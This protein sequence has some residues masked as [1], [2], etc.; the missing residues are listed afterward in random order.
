MSSNNTDNYMYNRLYLKNVPA[1]I[2]KNQLKNIFFKDLDNLDIHFPKNQK[3]IIP[4]KKVAFIQFSTPNEGKLARQVINLM[5]WNNVQANFANKA[6]SDNKIISA[7]TNQVINEEE[8]I[9][10][11]CGTVDS[12]F[13]CIECETLYYSTFYCSAEHQQKDWPRHKI[14]CKKLP[15]LKRI[16]ERQNVFKTND[17]HE[18]NNLEEDRQK[19]TIA[20]IDFSWI[21]GSKFLITHVATN[22]IIYVRPIDSQNSGYDQMLQLIKTKSLE[23][24]K[25]DEPPDVHD[26]ILAPYENSYYRARVQ[27]VF[28]TE[29]DGNKYKVQFTDIGNEATFSLS[30]LRRLT[31]KLRALPTHVFKV[32]L[33]GVDVTG[34]NQIISYLNEIYCKKDA[35][36][37]VAIRNNTNGVLRRVVFK[38]VNSGLII[39]D[40]VNELVQKIYFNNQLIPKIS[41]SNPVKLGIA[42]SSQLERKNIL[43]CMPFELFSL[44]EIMLNEI[45]EYCRLCNSIQYTPTL[46][47]IYLLKYQ[48]KWHR[49]INS[50]EKNTILIDKMINI[51]F[52]ENQGIRKIP[53]IYARKLFTSLCYVEKISLDDKKKLLHKNFACFNVTL[54]AQTKCIVLELATN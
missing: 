49:A 1:E 35:V 31:Y 53:Q 45:Q 54:D 50:K 24:P 22:R 30:S 25:C 18:T 4:D 15:Q 10:S 2:T 36:E 26:Y 17:E 44:Y 27:D 37:L 8:K 19:Y 39:N 48:D 16:S 12:E 23:A 21:E 20:N 41:S 28:E 52:E 29:N 9:C 3:T 11:Y 47:E 14:E 32:L 42:D 51:P 6:N 7:V 13:S 38:H 33:D 5:E 40:Y 43:A 46:N 34:N